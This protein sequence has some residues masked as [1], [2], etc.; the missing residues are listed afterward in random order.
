VSL[1]VLLSTVFSTD[2]RLSF[3]FLLLTLAYVLCFY[4]AIDLVAQRQLI[5]SII[6][7]IL[8]TALIICLV[9]LFEY[10][11][12][13]AGDWLGEI[14]RRAANIPWDLSTSRRIK[15]VLNNPNILAYYLL[16]VLGF[17]LYKFSLTRQPLL[18]LV[19][20][21]YFMLILG[22]SFLTQSRGGL[23]GAAIVLIIF[24]TL[25]WFDSLKLWVSS[26][27]RLRIFLY[28]ALGLVVISGLAFLL[29]P[30][31]SRTGNLASLN[32]SQRDSIWQIALATI[33]AFPWL[34]SGPG[35]FGQ[36]YLLFR[37][38]GDDFLHSHAHNLW[39]TFTA[40]GGFIGLAAVLY[41]NLAFVR[42]IPK[43]LLSALP[44]NSRV[45]TI[46][47]LAGLGGMTIHNLLDDFPDYPMLTLHVIFLVALC[48]KLGPAKPDTAPTV[49]RWDNLP[50]LLAICL[51]LLVIGGGLWFQPA[52][53]TYDEARAA[54]AQDDWPQTAKYLEQAVAADPNYNF[55]RQ[56]LALVYGKLALE[57]ESFVPQ[58]LTQQTAVLQHN[59]HYSL[60]YANLACLYQQ[61]GDLLSAIQAMQQAIALEPPQI[62]NTAVTQVSR[63]AYQ[64]S[65]VQ[66]YQQSNQTEAAQELSEQILTIAPWVA[67]SPFWAE[68]P[69][70]L[71]TLITSLEQAEPNTSPTKLA[72]LADLYFYSG[73]TQ[74]SLEL[75]HQL[76]N[77]P[78]LET[79]TLTRLGQNLA[80]LGDFVAALTVLNQAL[81]QT[82]YDPA[83][84]LIRAQVLLQQ[85]K[86]AEAE[87]DLRV[88]LATAPNPEAYTLWG[89]LAQQQGQ[90]SEAQQRYQ[91]AIAAATGS[92]TDYAY[93]VWRR[94]PLPEEALPCLV[95]PYTPQKLSQPALLLAQLQEQDRQPAAALETYQLLLRYEPYNS[96]A[97]QRL[98]ALCANSPGLCPQA[99]TPGP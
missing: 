26:S 51:A 63:L 74:R 94:N 41:L 77:Q 65:L 15:S 32:L 79:A 89:Q 8:L 3:D 67:A 80:Q 34:G 52:F 42:A 45:L 31:F 1:T 46:V 14:S 64:F 99:E 44:E 9:G 60:D 68:H 12:W 59:P 27:N 92:R 90:F 17:T 23:L 96:T 97:R 43:A 93:V 50:N 87:T 72:A 13:Y 88:V 35:A 84:R 39:L 69:Q 98:D 57:D 25:H 83:V 70:Q 61:T 21:T 40:E 82:P 73:Q 54:A 5:D 4:L 62:Q 85:H 36:Q 95:S 24:G 48:L 20:G 47:A 78:G 66:L 30:I 71:Q 28:L 91:K 11:Q 76:Q 37:Q 75:V 19:W 53:T 81:T 7:A 55:Y 49:S 33:R 29:W 18:R 22:V 58:A 2:P 38:P 6:N 10:W 16:P 56:Q 86:F